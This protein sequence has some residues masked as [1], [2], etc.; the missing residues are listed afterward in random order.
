MVGH[1]EQR[2][3]WLFFA[4]LCLRDGEEEVIKDQT[5]TQSVNLNWISHL[6]HFIELVKFMPESVFHTNCGTSLKGRE[7]ILG[8]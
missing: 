7:Y 6:P 4:S 1:G 8:A 5:T 3:L 2:H